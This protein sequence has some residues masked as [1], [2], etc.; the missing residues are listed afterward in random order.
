MKS[1]ILNNFSDISLQQIK[2]PLF[3]IYKSPKDFEGKY[4]TRLFNVEHPTEYCVVKD[5]LEQ[6]REVLPEGLTK[7]DRQP[8]DDPVIVEVW[9]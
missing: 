4:V 8:Q 2:V 7:I 3:T 5:T 6:A 9:L 1:T